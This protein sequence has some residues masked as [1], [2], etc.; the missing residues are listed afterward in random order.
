MTTW[1]D[2]GYRFNLA[3]L[4][5]KFTN[6]K[7]WKS[8][9]SKIDDFLDGGSFDNYEFKKVNNGAEMADDR[10]Y[11]DI[12][13][14]ANRHFKPKDDQP[15]FLD[16][17]AN[18]PKII[19]G[20]Q[21]VYKVFYML[22]DVSSMLNPDEK[23]NGSIRAFHNNSLRLAAISSMNQPANYEPYIKAADSA[24][25]GCLERYGVIH[26]TVQQLMTLHRQK[27][28]TRQK[29]RWTVG[30]IYPN[31][32]P[33]LGIKTFNVVHAAGVMLVY[34]IRLG[35]I[36]QVFALDY[37]SQQRLHQLSASYLY[38]TLYADLCTSTGLKI[39]LSTPINSYLNMILEK[40]K[41]VTSRTAQI[42]CKCFKKAYEVFLA[43]YAGHGNRMNTKHLVDDFAIKGYDK[44]VDLNMVIK[45]IFRAHPRYYL[46]V[47]RVFKVLPAPD[48]DLG[49]TMY[50][51][52]KKHHDPSPHVP[53]NTPYAPKDDKNTFEK[54]SFIGLIYYMRYLWIAYRIKVDK[55]SPGVV[56]EE[57]REEDW[58]QNYISRGALPQGAD[59]SWTNKIDL[60]GSYVY[61]E[62]TR[63]VLFTL[64][65]KTLGYDTLHEAL[66]NSP[67]DRMMRSQV[68]RMLV[69]SEISNF[70]PAPTLNFDFV[71]TVSPKPEAHKDVAR[72]FYMNN[73]RGR[74]TLSELE[75]NIG[76][77]CKELPG[78]AIG[79]GTVEI[80]KAMHELCQLAVDSGSIFL[81]TD[82]EGWSPKMN[83][84]IQQ[85]CL[86]FWSEIFNKPEISKYSKIWF[87]AD[88]VMNKKNYICTYKN[89]CA[90][91]DGYN[92]KMLTFMH[93]AVAGYATRIAR[94]RDESISPA[95]TEI[96]I[97]DVVIRVTCKIE[98]LNEAT[99]IFFDSLCMVYDAVG[100]KIDKNKS[101]VSNHMCIFLN[102]VY[103]LGS[104][105][106]YGSR[107]AVRLGTIIRSPTDS[108]ADMIDASRAAIEGCIKAGA[109]IYVAYSLFLVNIAWIHNKWD[110][111][112]DM[113]STK[114]AFMQY[115][116]RAFGGYGLPNIIGVS[117]NLASN[118]VTEGIG[119]IQEVAFFY[120]EFQ[121]IYEKVLK[122]KLVEKS[123]VQIITLPAG[124]ATNRAIIN[125]GRVSREIVR[126]IVNLS[127]NSV[128]SDVIKIGLS[129]K[130]DDIADD[131]VKSNDTI[132]AYTIDR[133]IKA[134]PIDML[135]QIVKK[136]ESA[137]TIR[138]LLGPKTIR[139]ISKQLRV[140]VYRVNGQ[141]KKI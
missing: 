80:K 52:Y 115:V 9:V 65:D 109:P 118:P 94:Q 21:A 110:S 39:D 57:F 42:L 90:N 96:F 107:A 68:T 30:S 48:Y 12:F 120:K 85:L 25:N 62:D 73:L 84:H 99:E 75:K 13:H 127:S 34:T 83:G 74:R 76:L 133:F 41:D 66:S 7:D 61:L 50:E 140:D 51:T 78:Y 91:F 4:I 130:L 114:F 36:D 55:R 5:A 40:M 134:T 70:L 44:V 60:T 98:R 33:I 15:L 137:N 123:N 16:V 54:P 23:L 59:L 28:Y 14:G 20:L 8:I 46:E 17:L 88:L 32:A 100:L 138:A 112:N 126:R 72:L 82:I 121:P 6:N 77:A 27:E 26:R 53:F 87:G 49:Q 2:C 35:K 69:D 95:R 97:D 81:N 37:V 92:G 71:H 119:I 111:F 47:A 113:R 141:M 122:C 93:V 104:H 139:K 43:L 136:I 86:D 45:I 89:T 64:K 29:R 63:D 19:I 103:S 79:K 108:F 10:V 102:E 3:H 56:K 106:T 131:I 125:K 129:A 116:P 117:S 67:G 124:V 105:L 58:V 22:N 101:I 1:D 128:V 31:Y 135:R 24:I 18:A 38:T 11:S 132:D